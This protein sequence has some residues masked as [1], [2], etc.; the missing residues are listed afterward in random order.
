MQNKN[1]TEVKQ[2]IAAD[3]QPIVLAAISTSVKQLKTFTYQ[4]RIHP[5]FE[6][7]KNAKKMR[8]LVRQLVNLMFDSAKNTGLLRKMSPAE[9]KKLQDAQGVK[10]ENKNVS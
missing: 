5:Q 9:L 7:P 2:K 6:D 4:T 1:K 8:K 3:D 10:V